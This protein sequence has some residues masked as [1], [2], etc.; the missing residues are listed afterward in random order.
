[1]DLLTID[2]HPCKSINAFDEVLD[3]NMKRLNNNKT[4]AV[5]MGD[6]NIDLNCSEYT[7][8]QNEYLNVLK[9]NGF[10]NLIIKPK[11][12]TATSQ[13]TIDHILSNDYDSVLMHGVFSF[14]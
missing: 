1:M 11:R 13:T 9:S 12:L 4:K 5:V 2:C 14:K 7:S 6:I 8:T 10:S 3:E